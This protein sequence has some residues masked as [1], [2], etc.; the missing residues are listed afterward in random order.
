MLPGLAHAQQSQSAA[1]TAVEEIT[2]TAQRRAETQQKVPIAVTAFTERDLANH[3]TD[4]LSGLQGAVPNMEL[5]QGRGSATAANITI[6]GIG[7]PDPLPTFDPG[8]GVYVD[9]VYIARVQG[10]LFDVYDTS[11]I[12]VLRGPQGT[13]YGKNTIGGAVKITTTEP[14]FTP[15][16]YAQIGLGDYGQVNAKAGFSDA[17]VPGELAA[18]AAFFDSQHDG[19]VTDTVTGQKYNDKDTKAGRVSLLWTPNPDLTVHVNVDETVDRPMP[20]LGRS[21]S[22][23]YQEDLGTG[24]VKI[25]QLAPTTRFNYTT[26]QSISSSFGNLNALDNTG[27][28]ITTDY[29]INE[30]LTFKSISAFRDLSSRQDLDIDGSRFELGDAYVGVGE[31]QTSQEF[32]INYDTAQFNLVGGFFFEHEHVKTD[33]LANANDFLT[34]FGLPLTTLRTR[35]DDTEDDSYAGFVNGTYHITAPLSINGGLRYGIESK[36]YTDATALYI[37][38]APSGVLPQQTLHATWYNLAPRFA[39]QYQLSDDAMSYASVSRGFKSGG[40]NGRAEEPGDLQPYA[41]EKVWTYEL[42]AKTDWFEHRLRLNGDVFYNDYTDFQAR[43]A[44]GNGLS[45]AFPVLNAASANTKGAELEA[46]AVPVKALELAAT[47][48]YLDAQYEQF[49]DPDPTAVHDRMAFSPHWTGRLSQ[50]YTFDLQNAG[51][52]R[53]SADENYRSKTWL[54]VDNEAGLSQDRFWLLN[55]RAAWESEDADWT[56][57]FAILNIAD[58]IYKTDAQNFT[59]LANI[60]TAYYGAPRTFSFTVGYHF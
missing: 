31:N 57:A 19:Y 35:E 9:D 29:R 41:P 32:Q 10:A 43:V 50:A 6:R 54:S 52:L 8:V 21:E 26:Q 60:Q 23:L 18:S 20:N 58:V 38:G 53:I 24:A 37:A 42:G 2:V 51:S 28:G 11:Q 17:I 40:F 49:T 22:F 27:I 59:S 13:L 39:V 15:T 36:D 25:L 14:S 12:E 16:G 33:Q 3:T 47:V 30:N 45:A 44:S 34:L 5:V 4:D 7:Q 56:A 46:T 1:A 55:A 48:G